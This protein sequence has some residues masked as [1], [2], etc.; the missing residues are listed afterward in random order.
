MT[1]DPSNHE[2]QGQPKRHDT[3]FPSHGL[4]NSRIGFSADES[5]FAG[6]LLFRLWRFVDQQVGRDQGHHTEFPPPRFEELAP[7][8]SETFAI[9]GAS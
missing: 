6:S 7:R 3:E 4:K 5:G 8:L 2:H 9:M 1:S